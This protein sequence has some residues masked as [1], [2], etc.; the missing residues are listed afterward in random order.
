MSSPER[1]CPKCQ[2][3]DIHARPKLGDWSCDNCGHSWKP[4]P[5]HPAEPSANAKVRLFLSYGRRDAKELAD[6]LA[7]DLTANGFAVWQDTCE[8]VTGTSWQHEIVDG[9]RS[10]Q[11]VVALMTPHSVRT[12][13]DSQNP[14]QADSVCLG[15]I[16]HALFQPPTRPVVP[17][18]ARSCEPPL[19]IIHL[20]YVDMRTWT[21]SADEYH[22][23]LKRLLDGI[24]AALRGEKRYRSWYHQL[25]PW[26]F[27]SFLY[28]KRQDFCGRQWL[29]D[30]ID[31][32]RTACGRERALL[33]KGDPGTGKSAIVAELVHRNPCGQ[34]LAY[35]CCQW[36][37]LETR[38]PWR[39]VRSIAAMIASKHDDYAALL[40]EPSVQ[41]ALG[42]ASCKSDPGSAFEKGVLNPLQHLH[43]PA[44]GP[45]YLL[46]DALDESLLVEPGTP[47]IVG[48]L[49]SR[50]DRLPPWLRIVA[51]TRKEVAVLSRLKGL[52][53]EE[54]DAQSAENLTDVRALITA[55]LNSPNLAEKLAE[56]H[57][58]EAAVAGLLCEKSQGNFLYV[59]QTLDG[60]ERGLHAM[61]KLDALPPG[62]EG[63]YLQRFGA[64]FP[65]A[66]RFATC[67]RVLDAI[68]A[69]REPL[70]KDELARATGLD[71]EEELPAVLKWLSAYV[72]SRPD[73]GDVPRYAA[74]H[75]SLVD[76]LTDPERRDEP[77]SASPKRG[78]QRL[79]DMCWQEYQRGPSSMSPY[80]LAHLPAH[81]TCAG[82][83]DDL[84]RLLCDLFYLEAKAQA[85]RVFELVQDFYGAVAAM[86]R[87]HP[88][89]RILELL[90]DAIRRDLQF[91]T[92]HP[93]SL[94]QCLWNRCWWYDCPAAEKYYEEAPVDPALPPWKRPGS[95][96]YSLLEEWRGAKETADLRFCWLRALRPLP[97]PLDG[98]LRL[99]I[100]GHRGT[101]HSVAYSP[102]GQQVI[103]GSED[104]TVRIWDAESGVELAVFRGHELDVR[105]VACS[106]DGRRIISAS[107]DH[108]VR[109]WDVESGAE[110]ATLRGHELM[111]QT[112]G[113]SPDGQ[114]IVS[115]SCDD[116][117]RIWDAGSGAAELAVFRGHE[118]SVTSVAY[119]P[120]GRQIISGSDDRTV[121]IWD[122]EKGTELA[123]FRGHEAEVRA[124]ACSPDGRRIISASDDGTV[125]V[126]DVESGAEVATL[127]GHELM[128]QTVGYSPDGQRI[129][130]GG[131]DNTVRIW[132]AGSGAELAILRNTQ[133]GQLVRS[134][135][136]APGGRRIASGASDGTV[137]IWDI[138]R[139]TKARVLRGHKVCGLAHSPDGRRIVSGHWDHTARVSSAE[140]GDETTVLRGHEGPVTCVAYSPDGNRIATGSVD[141]TVRVWDAESGDEIIVLR[142]HEGSVTHVAYSPDGKWIASSTGDH[143]GHGC[144]TRLADDT[145]RVWDAES[146]AEV[147][148]QRG[149]LGVIT[150]MAFSSDGRRIAS[151]M[152]TIGGLGFFAMSGFSGS[153]I[154]GNGASIESS[155]V[156]DSI[157]YYGTVRVW[158]VETG[159]EMAVLRGHEMAVTCVA[160]SPDG[161]R[162]AS[163]S[164]DHSVRVWDSETGD[165]LAVL[166]GH[167]STVFNV[168][169]SPDGS[170]I[171]S[172]SKD[173]TVRIWDSNLADCVDVIEGT[174]DVKAIAGS[175][176]QLR[177]RAVARD[178]ETV[179]ESAGVDKPIAWFQASLEHITTLP[180][181][182]GWVGTLE[183][184]FNIL[185]LEG[186][187]KVPLAPI[188]NEAAIDLRLAMILRK[189]QF[190]QRLSAHEPTNIELQLD[191]SI[192]HDKVGDVLLSQD[193]YSGAL[194]AY[195][196][197]FA[198]RERLSVSEP[199]SSNW[200][201]LLSISHVRIGDVFFSQG[202]FAKALVEYRKDL[203]IAEHLAAVG[204]NN[205]EWQ[206]D[207][208]FSYSRVAY[209][210]TQTNDEIQAGKHWHACHR[211]LRGMRTSGMPLDPPLKEL[212]D[213][214]ESE[215]V[216]RGDDGL[217]GEVDESG[218]AAREDTRD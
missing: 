169:F 32:W 117:V 43:A 151:G 46:I 140:D 215:G 103:S 195:R 100:R 213:Q 118:K 139:G 18:M 132:D 82:R 1:I 164:H 119:S 56:S 197:S 187:E 15:E 89:H 171:A 141:H 210:L 80:A 173:G 78:H 186:A 166:R 150:S 178:S 90:E 57:L 58:S 176:S 203:T 205:A 95:K 188:E 52:S 111:V 30:R 207:V 49:E 108:T 170:L 65:D 163:G 94:F 23:G 102:V 134:V 136:F 96:L 127:R 88:K 217:V 152:E 72:P 86:P 190:L 9:L 204:P 185:A 192:S 79:A 21:E 91:L 200:Q 113:Y 145:V 63:V 73:A 74:Y 37:V 51:T 53:A 159:A 144:F 33:I 101:V 129:V 12:T 45:R 60:I 114:R 75:K 11:V 180:S 36:D 27:A 161:R 201:R 81:L 216:P 184:T 198:I 208:A 14:D 17:V 143:D 116:T 181:G 153:A 196:A 121:R 26:D 7:I 25:D 130:S 3:D 135:G 83:W 2:S 124:V 137:R 24:Q 92:R 31:A 123:V 66:E 154:E 48:L 191:L 50:L 10:A 67:R 34:V 47:T 146:G 54:L 62:L 147:S 55:R 193:D 133:D 126:W 149:K 77:H 87:E 71:A 162:I 99:V 218:T 214:M 97:E 142:G 110:V 120:D 109:V 160:Y 194:A 158:N 211:V 61:D 8:I 4:E 29:F 183:A 157:D 165:E 6:R 40:Q 98:A 106:P 182:R 168:A 128:V 35:H 212:L 125:R 93:H 122:A 189:R 5:G 202:E 209:C 38:Q 59:Q 39:F 179:V 107:D 44:D 16:S 84:E 70:A 28:A 177:Y 167:S 175:V 104:R 172:A 138:D 131:W 155:S 199:A 42:E 13:G 64:Q 85:G 115:G 105:A 148:V 22:A 69:A 41:E 68:V 112:V 19:P 156:E 174:G 76:W 206:A 20:D